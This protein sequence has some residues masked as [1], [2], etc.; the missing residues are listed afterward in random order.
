MDQDAGLTWGPLG[1]M[2]L[3]FYLF[4]SKKHDSQVQCVDQQA[5]PGNWLEI[6]TQLG[7][8]LPCRSS[9]RG[10]LALDVCTHSPGGSDARLGTPEPEEPKLLDSWDWMR[11]Q[12]R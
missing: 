6:E 9:G 3:S 7:V 12:A 8:T 5:P 2:T 4:F 10:D 11:R 1:S